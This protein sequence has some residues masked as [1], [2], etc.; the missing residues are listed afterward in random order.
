MLAASERRRQSIVWRAGDENTDLSVLLPTLRFFS[1]LRARSTVNIKVICAID[2]TSRALTA[3]A[4]FRNRMHRR[5]FR[6]NGALLFYRLHCNYPK[7]P[8][9][10]RLERC[11]ACRSLTAREISQ[12]YVK[13]TRPAWICPEIR[14]ARIAIIRA[15]IFAFPPNDTHA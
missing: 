8:W 5:G 13:R 7:L 15:C 14:E 9:E 11:L 3:R 1:I 12:R 10:R 6:Q 4:Y 2:S